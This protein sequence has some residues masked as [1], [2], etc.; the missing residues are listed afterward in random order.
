[1]AW[2]LRPRTSAFANWC[3]ES[4]SEP[5]PPVAT[6]SRGESSEGAVE[7]LLRPRVVGGV[8][9]LPRALLVGEPEQAE[10]ADLVRVGPEGGLEL[11]HDGGGAAASGR[12][13]GLE[14]PARRGRRDEWRGRRRRAL[15]EDAAEEE[16]D[17]RQRGCRCSE[18]Q[19]LPS[20]PLCSLGRG[21]EGLRF[22]PSRPLA[23]APGPREPRSPGAGTPRTGT[24]SRTRR[25]SRPR[26][27]R[28]V[29]RRL[30][31]KAERAGQERA[32]P[33]GDRPQ[34][35][36]DDVVTEAAAVREPAEVGRRAR[37]SGPGPPR[38]PCHRG[39]PR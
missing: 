38:T 18:Y 29:V 32:V 26:R 3:R 39:R 12:E 15:T 10:R 33:L 16:C 35:D 17:H 30:V 28:D 23:V 5:R 1:M 11:A 20:H 2:A 8:S 7:R 31:R 27:R 37:P 24:C 4:A 9:R 36:V 6:R 19:S 14:L 22:R 13:A 25:R 21:R 34:L